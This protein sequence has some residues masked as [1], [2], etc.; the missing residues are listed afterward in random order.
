MSQV[1]KHHFED[2]RSQALSPDGKRLVV[3][4]IDYYVR[5]YDA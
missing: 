4:S 2:V 1:L 3:A 5:I